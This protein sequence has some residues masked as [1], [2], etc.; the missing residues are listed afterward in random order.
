METLKVLSV[1]AEFS[2]IDGDGGGGGE[3]ARQQLA[4]CSLLLAGKGR[5]L[6]PTVHFHHGAFV[7]PRQSW[8]HTTS[9]NKTFFLQTTY[10]AIFFT[11]TKA[12]ILIFLLCLQNVGQTSRPV[13]AQAKFILFSRSFDECSCLKLFTQLKLSTRRIS[14]PGP[15]RQESFFFKLSGFGFFYEAKEQNSN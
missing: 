3:Q 15:A 11:A 2:S 7:L 8:T 10:S 9:Q 1:Y 12:D 5:T 6:P 13:Q 14:L 4:L